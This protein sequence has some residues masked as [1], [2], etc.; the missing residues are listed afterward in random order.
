MILLKKDRKN[1]DWR[2]SR[3]W[4]RR[5]K[6]RKKHK[7]LNPKKLLTRFLTFFAQIKAGNNSYKLKTEIRQ[8]VYLL[9]QHNKTTKNFTT[10]NQVIII[11]EDYMVVITE[12]KNFYFYFYLTKGVGKSWKH[13]I[14]FVIKRNE[15]IAKHMRLIK[16]C[17]NI[18][19]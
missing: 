5:S 8:I 9:Y 11:I 6:R 7:N 3:K 18:S 2:T 19:M 14:E 4:R 16:Y 10:I 12:H 15:S 17:L 1:K 13:E